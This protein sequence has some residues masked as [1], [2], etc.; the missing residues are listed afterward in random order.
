MPDLVIQ[1]CGSLEAAAQF[2]LDN[3]A[4]IGD[5]PTV[6]NTYLITDVATAIAGTE[7]SA[8]LLDLQKNGTVIG[9]LATIPPP[10]LAYT[11][12]LYP[13]LKAAASVT[14]DPA[15]LRYWKFDITDDV[16]FINVDPLTGWRTDNHLNSLPVNTYFSGG[17]GII[18]LPISTATFPTFDLTYKIV[19]SHADYELVWG[20]AIAPVDSSGNYASVIPVII[21]D[22]TTETV[23]EFLVPQLDID[24]VTATPAS[25]TL[26]ITRSHPA[27]NP[28]LGDASITGVTM[29]WG[30]VAS[31][32]TPDPM[33]P[34]NPDKVIVT[35]TPGIYRI[36]LTAA[37]TTPPAPIALPTSQ[38]EMIIQIS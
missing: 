15:I 30:S 16:G 31:G 8:I 20:S 32:G 35:L 14:G 26:R 29:S 37:Y 36:G 33:D 23:L 5:I 9:T 25:V 3:S 1:G 18:N 21:L 11:I 2:C 4:A 10:D 19:W 24:L 38:T 12:L 17:A 6:G 28:S 27:V 22:Q 7:G 13:V 34:T